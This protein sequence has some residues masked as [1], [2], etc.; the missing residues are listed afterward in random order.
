MQKLIWI[1]SLV[2]VVIAGAHAELKK[3][4]PVKILVIGPSFAQNATQFLP[5]VFS[6]SS[7]ELILKTLISG[8]VSLDFW[9]AV[10]QQEQGREV[11]GELGQSAKNYIELR[12]QK[13]EL[14]LTESVVAEE[15]DFI[16]VQQNSQQARRTETFEPHLKEILDFIH[17][18]APQAEVLLHQAWAYRLDGEAC[19]EMYE[20]LNA[21]YAAMARKYGLRIIPAAQAV[22]AVRQ[23]PEWVPTDFTAEQRSQCR[24]PELPYTGKTL[25]TYWHWND[26]ALKKD[27]LHLNDTGKWFIASLWYAFFTQEEAVSVAFI[28]EGVNRKDGS[29]L[30]QIADETLSSYAVE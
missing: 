11:A 27:A 30:L 15:W 22:Q 26:G 9:A 1:L 20:E 16:T 14:S 7:H 23:I 24:P 21:G 5:D 29:S 19:Q 2:G 6:G 25:V 13:G 4:N 18:H 3:E 8:G 28:P 10:I 12:K 17:M